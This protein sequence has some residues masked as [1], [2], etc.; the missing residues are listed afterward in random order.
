MLR[1]ISLQC[2]GISVR[3]L[4]IGQLTIDVLL[5]QS[6]GLHKL[7]DCNDICNNFLYL[8]IN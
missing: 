8:E 1:R 3:N 6:V 4:L 2:I 7:F 5:L